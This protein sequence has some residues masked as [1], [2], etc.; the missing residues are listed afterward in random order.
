MVDD[1]KATE[2]FVMDGWTD[3]HTM[4][5]RYTP[6][7]SERGYFNIGEGYIDNNDGES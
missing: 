5:K 3:R 2:S 1:K 6:C 4:I 7:P